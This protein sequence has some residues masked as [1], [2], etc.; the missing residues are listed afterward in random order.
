MGCFPH[1]SAVDLPADIDERN[2][3]GPSGRLL[4]SLT[5]SGG[6]PSKA[7]GAVPRSGSPR[8]GLAQPAA[9]GKGIKLLSITP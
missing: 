5:A 3:T 8:Y 9:V 2:R 6:F 7:C 1:L 4:H